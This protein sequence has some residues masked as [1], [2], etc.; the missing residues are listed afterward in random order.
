MP[1]RIMLISDN[2]QLCTVEAIVHR[3]LLVFRQKPPFQPLAFTSGKTTTNP[4]DL[5]IKEAACSYFMFEFQFRMCVEV[6]D[7]RT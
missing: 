2:H 4:N 7:E 3:I 1:L 5:F 6:E